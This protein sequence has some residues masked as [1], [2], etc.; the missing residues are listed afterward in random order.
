MQRRLYRRASLAAQRRCIPL[1][2]TLGRMEFIRSNIVA[3]WVA[4]Q[5]AGCASTLADGARVHLGGQSFLELRLPV[6]WEF[7]VAYT[8]PPT[9]DRV[10]VFNGAT[11]AL[12]VFPLTWNNVKAPTGHS[13][14]DLRSRA[15][16]ALEQSKFCSNLPVDE[17]I[18]DEGLALSCNVPTASGGRQTFGALANTHITAAFSFQENV[19]APSARIWKVLQ[20]VRHF[21]FEHAA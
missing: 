21:S 13:A 16:T 19:T 18:L 10:R 3:I 4:V 9:V 2:S 7:R 20:T 15:R 8:S 1:S 5:L 17:R 14:D 6:G 12:Q 11:E